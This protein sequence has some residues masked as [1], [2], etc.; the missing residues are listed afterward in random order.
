MSDP[1]HT[2][3][4][5]RIEGRR[6]EPYGAFSVTRTGAAAIALGGEL[7]LAAAPAL[8]RELEAVGEV[9]RLVLD[10]SET[11]FVDSS[12]LRELLAANAAARERGGVLVLAGIPAPVRR[13]LELTGTLELFELQGS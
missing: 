1:G 5:S 9:P 4:E 10:V 8:R 7:D 6:L 11:T 3:H 2:L 12:V 13:L